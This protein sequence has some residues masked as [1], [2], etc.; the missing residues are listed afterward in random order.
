MM[1]KV[2][3]HDEEKKNCGKKKLKKERQHK[4]SIQTLYPTPAIK[5]I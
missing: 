2:E 3:L 4:K 1:R 5:S